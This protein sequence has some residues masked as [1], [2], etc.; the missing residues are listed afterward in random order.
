[1]DKKLLCRTTGS[2]G[3]FLSPA[4]LSCAIVASS[5]ASV[6]QAA[7]VVE[8]RKSGLSQLP[9]PALEHSKGLAT[10]TLLGL[11][12]N[13]QLKTIKEFTDKRGNHYQRLNQEY[14]GVP[15]W[16][17]QVI[18]NRNADDK[19][20]R[21]HGRMVN[22]IEADLPS[23][24]TKLKASDV[25]Q[26]RKDLEKKRSFSENA[27]EQFKYENERSELFVYIDESGKARLVYEVSFF[28]DNVNGGQPNRPFAIV[29]ANSGEVLKSWNGLA[30]QQATGPG[31]N[32]KSGQYQYGSDRPHLEVDEN[33]R[34][35]NARVKT[36]DM[37]NEKS[38]GEV[39][40]FTCPENSERQV[41]GAYSPLNDAHYYGDLVYNLYQDW[42]GVAPLDMQLEMRVHYGD[43][44]KNAFW[45]GSSMTFGD[46]DL[47]SYYPFTTLNISAHEVSHGFTEQNSKLAYFGHSGGMNEAFSDMAGEAAEFYL[48]GSNDFL[49]GVHVKKG[50]NAV[51]RYMQ[52]P[53]QDG[54]SIGHAD[55]YVK[56]LDVHYS[57]GVYNR[58]FYLLANTAGWDTRKAFEVMARANQLYWYRNSDFNWGACG[59]MDAAN[60]LAYSEADVVSAFA[61]VGVSCPDTGAATLRVYNPEEGRIYSMFTSQEV[62]N[63]RVGANAYDRYDFDLAGAVV[64]SSDMTGH[65]ATGWQ[66]TFP[67]YYG[68]NV[69]TATVTNSRGVSTIVERNVRVQ[70]SPEPNIISPQNGAVYQEGD[71]IH[72]SAT[73][74][75]FEDGDVSDSIVWSLERGASYEGELGRGSEL[76]VVLEPI[77]FNDVYYKIR[78]VAYDSDGGVRGTQVYSIDV[79]PAPKPEY[80]ITLTVTT[81]SNIFGKYAK[82]TWEG[83]EH[84]INVYRD[85]ERTLDIGAPSGTHVSNFYYSGETRFKVCEVVPY[86][87]VCSNEVVV[88]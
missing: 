15:V 8:L 36:V 17:E 5:F 40:Q 6:T 26:Q 37:A 33:C 18:I 39:H 72:L 79:I 75:D 60:D 14:R 16:G 38:G 64:W 28:V 51:M 71:I 81:H 58:A 69:L 35:E 66:P 67:L 54:K 27:T 82:L 49:I 59:V 12:K 56:G 3:A 7:N 73:A 21:L 74:S 52:D 10:A 41:N 24:K 23:V 32:P 44:Y 85:G 43:N 25:L 88:D 30:H 70:Y 47:F 76:D 2:G 84:W 1:M 48:T 9:A 86:D 11:Q 83:D 80:P 22:G 57:S 13:N 46:G 68:P 4:L 20:T 77:L 63:A 62:T 29:D 42:V 65:V 19:V 31:G 45:N 61:Q 55:D 53:T 87:G 50:L 78:A 34:M